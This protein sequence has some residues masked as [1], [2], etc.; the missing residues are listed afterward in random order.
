MEHP[1]ILVA[2]P[3]HGANVKLQFVNSL[4]QT[5]RMFERGGIRHGFLGAAH[6]DIAASRNFLASFMFERPQF[7][8]LLFID[9]DMA[10]APD[11]VEKLV[12]ADRPLIGCVCPRRQIDLAAFARLSGK[13]APPAV[14]AAGALEFV[15][16]Y[17]PDRRS[18]QISAGMC[19]VLGV[20]MALTLIHRSVFSALVAKG[21]IVR[22]DRHL[23]ANEG[24]KGPMFGFFDPIADGAAGFISEDFS[25]CE[26]WVKRCGGETWALTDV[27]VQH[28]GDFAYSASYA[29]HLAA[30]Q[31]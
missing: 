19:A 18:V 14:A 12:A 13:G 20:G 11:V 8:H 22:Y 30:R 26:R 28:I 4:M 7:T 5:Q 2:T 15:V 24:L 25:F 29:D 21:D 17:P 1:N 10:F 27:V 3:A 9:S 31:I 6:A 16:R 23:F